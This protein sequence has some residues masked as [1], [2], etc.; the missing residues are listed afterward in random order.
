MR[1]LTNLVLLLLCLGANAQL[2]VQDIM[3]KNVSVKYIN[4]PLEKVFIDLR[5]RYNVGFS[6]SSMN[7]PVNR[8]VSLVAKNKPLKWV[9]EEVLKDLELESV[10]VE[11]Q[12]VIKKAKPKPKAARESQIVPMATASNNSYQREMEIRQA[13]IELLADSIRSLKNEVIRLTEIIDSISTNAV[14]PKRDTVA[15]EGKIVVEDLKNESKKLNDRISELANKL[16]TVLKTTDTTKVGLESKMYFY[17][18]AYNHLPAGFKYP[19]VGFVNVVNGYYDGGLALGFINYIGGDAKGA[20][21]GYVNLS[22]GNFD[23]LQIGY[24]NGNNGFVKGSQFGFVNVNNGNMDG[25]EFGYVNIN[26]GSSKGAQFGFVN[27]NTDSVRGARFGFVNVNEGNFKGFDAGF[28]NANDGDSKATTLGFV[29]A[30]TGDRT[31]VD[32][33]FVN[34][35]DKFKKGFAI[36]F[37]NIYDTVNAKALPIGFLTIARNGYYKLEVGASDVFQPQALFKLGVKK[38]YTQF[39][40]GA[41]LFQNELAWGYAFGIGS[42]W[43][44]GKG[45]DFSLEAVSWQILEKGYTFDNDTY[46]AIHQ[47]RTVFAKNITP[48]TSVFLAPSFNVSVATNKNKEYKGS[49]LPVYDLFDETYNDTNVKMWVGASAGLRF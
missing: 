40:A 39:G 29:N 45:Y 11:G 43:D 36:G 47:I 33:G 21:I 17:T 19:A 37:V 23:G 13:E 8:P 1:K 4:T 46:N 25:A 16:R 15:V 10:A 41:N 3:E 49:A 2:Q 34:I 35:A 22:N 5:D 44:M 20:D 24:V 31:G 12:I 26:N 28:V 48:K 42:R 7:V 27:I 38:F 30:N 18:V 32:I 9:L 14:Q 6:Y